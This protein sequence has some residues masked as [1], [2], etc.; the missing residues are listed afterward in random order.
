VSIEQVAEK[1]PFLVLAIA[2]MIVVVLVVMPLP[3][4]I[5][6][7]GIRNGGNGSG[8]GSRRLAD[9]QFLDGTL[10]NLVQLS[11][12][13]PDAPALRTVI[14]LYTLTFGHLQCDI[15]CGTVHVFTP[16]FAVESFIDTCT[17]TS[18]AP[19]PWGFGVNVV[20]E[21]P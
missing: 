9:R 4:H 3:S 15:A 17:A 20:P 21:H 11:P 19:V 2:V 12:V 7:L 1:T 6:P 13:Q 10:D 14:D 18:A 16:Y 8:T 5:V